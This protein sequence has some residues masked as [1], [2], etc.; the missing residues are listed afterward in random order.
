MQRAHRAEQR[1]PVGD[2]VEGRAAV[3]RSDGH[4]G[5][6]HRPHLA[7][8]HRLQLRH[9]RAGG[10]HRIHRLVRQRRM[11]GAAAHRDLEPVGGGHRRSRAPA[12]GAHRHG[13]M[14]VEAER[15]VDARERAVGDHRG[16]A[17]HALLGGLEQQLDASADLRRHLLEHRGDPQQRARMDVMPAG[18][19]PARHGAGVGEARPLLDRQRVHVGPDGQGRPG[20][21]A[22]QRADH[23]RAAD[24]SL[25]RNAE[26]AQLLG[27]ERGG[28]HLL[29]GQLGMSVDVASQPDQPRVQFGHAIGESGLEVVTQHHAAACPHRPAPWPMPSSGSDHG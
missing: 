29:E 13:G 21:T 7:R 19:H 24:P 11:A 6:M 12:E 18:V 25:D 8:H 16:G 17:A 1:H 23:S 9:Q 26:A 22:D 3:N 4:H 5:R 2:D 14:V 20:P 15:H 28:P 27:H 10:D